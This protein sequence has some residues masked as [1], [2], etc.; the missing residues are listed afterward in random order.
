MIPLKV[1]WT[2]L[3]AVAT[4]AAA[5][6]LAL[7]HAPILVSS[8]A[9]VAAAIAVATAAR[10]VVP[11]ADVFD[12]VT[13]ER[14]RTLVRWIGAGAGVH[15]AWG[16]LFQIRPELWLYWLAGICVIAGVEYGVCRSHEYM[17]TRRTPRADLAAATSATVAATP[18]RTS[19]LR[20]PEE[21]VRERLTWA[22]L[23]SGHSWL[24]ITEPGVIVST[25]SRQ[26]IGITALLE[27]EFMPVEQ[28]NDTRPTSRRR[29]PS[30]KVEL[31]A[32]DR[33]RMAIAFRQITNVKLHSDWVTLI[34]QPDAG[35]YQLV[36]LFEDVLSTVYPYV[37]DPTPTT[38][39]QPMMVGYQV[40]GE[41]FYR[42]LDQHGVDIGSSRMGKS[43]KV[44]CKFGDTTR[45]TNGVQ[46]VCGTSKLYDLLAG[47][48]EPYKDQPVKH[49]FNW[50]VSG[51]EHSLIMMAT[52]LV[53]ARWRQN[54][55]MDARAGFKTIFLQFDEANAQSAL[56]NTTI[57]IK[58]EGVDYT[59]S[60]LALSLVNE[61]GGGEVWL[62]LAGHR[63]TDPNLGP[64]TTDIT[65]GL[66]WR[67]IFHVGDVAEIGRATD[68]YN[69]DNPSHKGE[70]WDNPGA[71]YPVTKLKSG[72]MQEI[73][74]GKDHLHDG[75]TIADVAWARRHFGHDLDEGSARV[76][77][78]FA[79]TLYSRRCEYVTEEFLAYLRQPALWT[80][81][82][83]APVST[84][85]AEPSGVSFDQ[86]QAEAEAELNELFGPL[87]SAD[88]AGA[89][90]AAEVGSATVVTTLPRTPIRER[91]VA[92][93][94]R[95][96]GEI[97]RAEI[98]AALAEE[99][100]PVGD[101]VVTNTLSYLTR[102]G[103][104][105]VRVAKNSYLAT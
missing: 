20:G 5:F 23:L 62:H 10:V 57:S 16:L 53:I 1:F 56:Q 89:G 58:I 52:G 29:K 31:T 59:M 91:I 28:P 35:V 18:N 54:Q 44:N 8:A 2:I 69:L 70:F 88:C 71:D 100:S 90:G 30:D 66:A 17:L 85:A 61:A 95:A 98:I 37:D 3:A 102:E 42:R 26:S 9:F 25:E 103:S 15:A 12:K 43:S 74:P 96:D 67:S 22:F 92:I 51:A 27:I 79:G 84:A 97:T 38:S 82:L 48:L 34:E 32:E 41:P 83:T 6:G 14:K 101:Q 81:A 68:D 73:D 36:V 24:R 40:N 55:P 104:E 11:V 33:K 4:F 45:M 78:E 19:D 50:V 99:G 47:W 87:P 63:M 21:Q 76:A 77:A 13:D 46:W 105:V 86:A 39:K 93:V 49:P 60:K 75:P 80:G 65:N 7:F 94:R 72:Y 64:F